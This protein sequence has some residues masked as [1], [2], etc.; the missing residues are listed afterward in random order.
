MEISVCS[1]VHAVRPI[2]AVMRQNMAFVQNI[3]S[4]KF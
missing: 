3:P 2:Y 1:Y 4:M